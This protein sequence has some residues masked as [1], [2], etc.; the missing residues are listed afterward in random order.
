[1]SGS[2]HARAARSRLDTFAPRTGSSDEDARPVD[3]V[4]PVSHHVSAPPPPVDRD[5]G[6]RVY[7]FTPP[8]ELILAWWFE[9]LSRWAE[10]RSWRWRVRHCDM[11]ANGYQYS[12]WR[13][14]YFRGARP[15]HLD[16]FNP[17]RGEILCTGTW[18]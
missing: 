4:D 17:E 16:R 10:T 1:V 5:T 12:R 11:C 18:K 14:G 9:C 2:G 8:P 3:L 13:E 7:D 6:M 15:F